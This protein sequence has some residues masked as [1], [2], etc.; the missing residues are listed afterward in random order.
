[1]LPN[2]TG[3]LIRPPLALP[4]I[5]E[6]GGVLIS[7]PARDCLVLVGTPGG[8]G[9]RGRGQVRVPASETR[10]SAE[11][12][13][14]RLDSNST[15]CQNRELRTCDAWSRPPTIAGMIT[16]KKPPGHKKQNKEPQTKKYTQPYRSPIPSCSSP[17]F[18]FHPSKP[19]L[20][21]IPLSNSRY[22]FLKI[23]PQRPRAINNIPESEHQ[24][25]LSPSNPPRSSR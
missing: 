6:R 22:D 18:I 4:N 9:Y 16:T 5:R 1:M 11:P 7:D 12:D 3:S 8:G 15:P 21:Q 17:S 23:D 13:L 10:I 20:N 2:T 25:Q 14:T 19:S 24:R